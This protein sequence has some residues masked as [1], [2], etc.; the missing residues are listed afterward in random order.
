MRLNRPRGVV[1]HRAMRG[2]VATLSKLVDAA[3]AVTRLGAK[4]QWLMI[5]EVVPH[6]QVRPR[7]SALLWESFF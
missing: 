5:E 1:P 2:V 7:C 3:V 6:E 4:V